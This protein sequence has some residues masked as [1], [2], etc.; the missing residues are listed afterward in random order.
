MRSLG[1]VHS[2]CWS[3]GASGRVPDEQVPCRR[4]SLGGGNV[5]DAFIADPE[6]VDEDGTILVTVDLGA[7]SRVDHWVEARGP[8]WAYLAIRGVG[9]SGSWGDRNYS[10]EWPLHDFEQWRR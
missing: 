9:D 10:P 5:A 3:A 7:G 4:D 1:V 8:E 2:I 6:T